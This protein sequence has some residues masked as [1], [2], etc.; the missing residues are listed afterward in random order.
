[1][2]E[3]G[4]EFICAPWD[5]AG[6]CDPSV[7]S[8]AA[9]LLATTTHW[10]ILPESMTKRGVVSLRLASAHVSLRSAQSCGC[11]ASIHLCLSCSFQLYVA[12]ALHGCSGA[13]LVCFNAACIHCMR[14]KYSK[15]SPALCLRSSP[16]WARCRVQ[17]IQLCKADPCMRMVPSVG[18]DLDAIFKKLLLANVHVTCHCSCGRLIL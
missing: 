5:S 11:R 7:P 14:A 8:G 9:V 10:T 16:V 1:M 4:Q 2:L 12:C 3:E 18:G 6:L 15:Q 13:C 17:K